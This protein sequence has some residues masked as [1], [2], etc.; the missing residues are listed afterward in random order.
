MITPVLFT[1]DTIG[2]PLCRSIQHVF[3]EDAISGGGVVDE[4]VGYG[5]DKFSVL[6]Y[7]ATRHADVK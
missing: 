2:L 5:A 7:R 3:D 4:D 6:D 1:V